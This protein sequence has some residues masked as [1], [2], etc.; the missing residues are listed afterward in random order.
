MATTTGSHSVASFT[1]PVNGTSPIDANAVRNN[2]NSLRTAY[3]DHDSDPGI[4]VQSSSLASRPVAGI[5]G[6]KWITVDTGVY[7]LWYDDGSVWHEVS[8]STI[9][10]EVLADANLVAGDVVKITGYNNGQGC[11]TVNKVSSAA[12]VA[13]G[14]VDSAI[15]L[16]TKGYIINTGI[17]RDINTNA[18]TVGTILYPNTSGGLTS[19]KPTS[20]SYQVCAYVLRQNVNNG[21]LFVEFSGSRIVESTANTA[22]TVVLRD[23]SGNFSAGTITATTLAAGTVTATT[24]ASDTVTATTLGGTLSTATQAN[25]TSLGTLTGLAVG[26]ATT[27]SAGAA[28]PALTATT[29]GSVQGSFRYDAGNRLDVQVTSAGQV[30]FNAVGTLPYISFADYIFMNIQ[31]PPGS[32]YAAAFLSSTGNAANPAYGVLGQGNGNHA[33]GTLSTVWGVTGSASVNAAGGTTTEAI[34]VRAEVTSAGILVNGYGI[35]VNAIS[36]SM[37]NAYGLRVRNVTGGTSLNYAIYTESGLVRFGDVVNTT[38]S[39]QVD[40]VKVVGNQ[41]AAVADATGTGDVVAQFNTLLARLRT[42]G[43]IA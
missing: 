8:N 40:G 26:G 39:Y 33:T 21:V 11:P 42:H 30:T 13:F 25:V 20:G 22:S 14:I 15:S 32:N 3:V 9:E 18:F 38:E 36:T 4:H 37:T 28:S 16:N 35:S 2:D 1:A 5:A 43:L 41:G 6:R 29:T 34:G 10:V 12:D 23:A 27:I 24:V 7:N 31:S 17:A 19:T